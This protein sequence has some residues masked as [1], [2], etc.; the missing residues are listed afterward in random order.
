MC[1]W[2]E[3]IGRLMDVIKVRQAVHVLFE[4]TDN[5]ELTVFFREKKMV[6]AS[7]NLFYKDAKE[8][9]TLFYIIDFAFIILYARPLR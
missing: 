2:H 8:I 3:R 1:S 5:L 7:L 9:F 6:L 4:S